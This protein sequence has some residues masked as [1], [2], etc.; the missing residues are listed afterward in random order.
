M[1]FQII[2]TLCFQFELFY[3]LLNN[4]LGFNSFSILELFKIITNFGIVCLSVASKW[5]KWL[6]SFSII[7]IAYFFSACVFYVLSNVWSSLFKKIDMCSFTFTTWILC[8]NLFIV[9]LFCFQQVSHVL[10][11]KWSAKHLLCLFIW[12]SYMLRLVWFGLVWFS[13]HLNYQN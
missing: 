11:M 5:L 6:T 10:R 7:P 13:F 12:S 3:F 4:I 1:R 9:C 8:G 2:T